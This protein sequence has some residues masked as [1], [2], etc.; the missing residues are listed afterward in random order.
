MNAD[1]EK[2]KLRM[3]AYLAAKLPAINADESREREPLM[4]LMRTDNTD[5]EKGKIE[6]KI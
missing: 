4:T 6:G 3:G 5:G 1:Q 2:E